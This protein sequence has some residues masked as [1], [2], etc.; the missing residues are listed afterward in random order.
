MNK[1]DQVTKGSCDLTR[2]VDQ[3]AKF[4][5]HR[6]CGI[7]EIMVLVGHVVLQGNVIKGYVT[8][9]VGSHQGKLSSC[10]VW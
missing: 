3:P 6:N 2:Q 9:Q 8:L 4:R 1:E 10:Q 5:V 7:A